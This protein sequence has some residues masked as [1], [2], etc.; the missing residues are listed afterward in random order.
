MHDLTAANMAALM[1]HAESLPKMIAA[2][3]VRALA[4]R[5]FE[6]DPRAAAEWAKASSMEWPLTQIWAKA[7]AESAF[8]AASTADKWWWSSLLSAA[9]AAKKGDDGAAQLA[10]ARTLPPG[11]KRDYAFAWVIRAWAERDPAGALAALDE[12]PVGPKRDDLRDS[13]LKGAAER[14]PAW[15]L[16]KVNEILPMLKAGLLGNEMVT[17]IA[18]NVAGKDP[19]LALDWL[20]GLPVEFRTAPSV[21]IAK[22]WANKEPL[23]ALEWCMAHGVDVTRA[24]WQGF[25]QWNPAM[26]AP[27]AGCVWLQSAGGVPA[28]WKQEWLAASG[29]GAEK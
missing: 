27:K 18:A 10:K 23:A 28:D 4:E 24:D 7:D 17:Q 16:A 11:R 29:S 26:L 5:W 1:K 3:L 2:E 12:I 21:R 14:D 6:L 15:T 8:R 19:R 22:T 20:S 9:L 25:S 13:L